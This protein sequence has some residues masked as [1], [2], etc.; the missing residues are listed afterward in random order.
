MKR[1]PRLKVPDR[2][3]RRIAFEDDPAVLR[4]PI[5]FFPHLFD[6]LGVPKRAASHVQVRQ[7]PRNAVIEYRG[8]ALM[9]QQQ[10]VRCDVE[11]NSHT[12]ANLFRGMFEAVP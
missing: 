5:D 11:L 10:L 6:G 3:R 7:R 1:L 12:L 8:P 4:D 9:F 2:Q